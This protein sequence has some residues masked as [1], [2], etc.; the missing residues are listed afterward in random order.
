MSRFSR[1]RLNLVHQFAT[2]RVGQKN[3]LN[4]QPSETVVGGDAGQPHGIPGE[5]TVGGQIIK[6]Q[7]NDELIALQ[8]K[9]LDK[10]FKWL[11]NLIIVVMGSGII[12]YS[13]TT[14]TSNKSPRQGF[15]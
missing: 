3:T 1:T 7:K 5:E 2:V 12:G 11:S 13:Y 8:L 4:V 15:S 10:D 6:L 9:K 14:G